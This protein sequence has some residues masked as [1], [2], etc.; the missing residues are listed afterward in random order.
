MRLDSTFCTAQHVPYLLVELA[1]SYKFEY[2]PLSRRQCSQTSAIRIQL[3][4]FGTRDFVTCE[5]TINCAKEVVGQ[6]LIRKSSAP[7]LMACAVV[8]MSRRPVR[9][10]IGNVEPSSSNRARK[11]ARSRRRSWS[12]SV[13]LKGRVRWRPTG[14]RAGGV[15][16]GP[17]PMLR[18]NNIRPK[19]AVEFHQI[20]TA[21]LAA[22]IERRSEVDLEVLERGRALFGRDAG[23]EGAATDAPPALRALIC[24]G[25]RAQGFREKMDAHRTSWGAE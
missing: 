13:G 25:F 6:C 19:A 21:L 18:I 5:R 8:W 11:V 22:L 16:D 9:N 7:A 17:P 23:V 10:I 14:Q 4:L 1:P 12:R 2:L 3:A 24:Q 15:S 20:G